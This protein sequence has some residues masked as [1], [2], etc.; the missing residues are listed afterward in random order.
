MTTPSTTEKRSG[1]CTGLESCVANTHLFR[2]RS[3]KR[4]AEFW[5][6]QG[7]HDLADVAAEFGV[8]LGEA[9]SEAPADTPEWVT[10]EFLAERAADRA[11]HRANGCKLHDEKLAKC[12]CP[13]QAQLS[14]E[15]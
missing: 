1:A 7:L 6:S 3:V 8:D 13:T 10:P 5:E 14:P 2:C 15:A 11:R 9:D 12:T 4:A